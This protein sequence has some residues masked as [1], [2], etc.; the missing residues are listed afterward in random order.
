[1]SAPVTKICAAV[2]VAGGARRRDIGH[3]RSTSAD[4]RTMR[5][6]RHDRH[7]DGAIRLTSTRGRHLA[8]HGDGDERQDDEREGQP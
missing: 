8:E 4:E 5:A 6:S 1:M 7:G 3:S 2:A